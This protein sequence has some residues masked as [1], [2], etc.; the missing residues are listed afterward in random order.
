MAWLDAGYKPPE[1]WFVKAEDYEDTIRV[2][3]PVGKITSAGE[4]PR[5]TKVLIESLSKY[6]GEI[7]ANWNRAKIW[8]ALIAREMAESRSEPGPR[9]PG[10]PAKEV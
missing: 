10:R 3:N 7:P 2:N 4:D 8:G 9:K 5:P 6:M 1:Q